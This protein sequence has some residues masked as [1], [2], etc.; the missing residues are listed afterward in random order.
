MRDG[1]G[2]LPVSA[3]DRISGSRHGRVDAPIMI[4][5]WSGGAPGMIGLDGCAQFGRRALRLKGA[6]AADGCAVGGEEVKATVGWLAE[7]RGVDGS[8]DE[9]GTDSA[10]WMAPRMCRGGGIAHVADRIMSGLRDRWRDSGP[11]PIDDVKKHLA[12]D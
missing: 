3:L 11:A 1:V 7:S 9:G 4:L 2:Q 12:P 8:E 10:A 5:R 6:V